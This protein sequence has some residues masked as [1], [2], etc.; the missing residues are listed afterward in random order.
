MNYI[1]AVVAGFVQGVTEFLPVSSTG[2]LIML[3]K[4]FGVSQEQFG[5]AFDASIH[6]GTLAA[7]LIFFWKDYINLYRNHALLIKLIIGT[8]PAVVFGLLFESLIESYFRQLWIVGATL[9]GFSI[10]MYI[11][12]KYGKKIRPGTTM[13]KRES[14]MVGT[15]QALALIPGISRSGSTMSAGLM[16]GLTRP[17]AAKFAFLL[18]GPIV[19]GAGLLKFSEVFTSQS[20]Q[21]DSFAYFV[22]GIISSCLFGF[23]T[24]KYFLK[25]ISKHSLYPFIGYRIAVGILLIIISISG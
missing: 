23:L 2:H 10:V 11:A 1:F 24:I 5:L 8:I 25:F 9:I 19:A 6:L 12:E 18:S 4:L 22:I 21:S 7:V 20:L 13:S 3:E 17:E 15:F 16:L 14:L